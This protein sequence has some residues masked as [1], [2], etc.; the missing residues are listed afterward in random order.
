MQKQANIQLLLDTHIFL[1][2]MNGENFLSSKNREYIEDVIEEEGS[3]GVSAISLW[4]I[5]MLHSRQ[6]ILLDQP[7][8]NW[9][10]H[11]LHAPGIYLAELTPEIAVDSCSL[12][13]E[14]HS[15][16]ADRIIVSTARILDVPLMTKDQKILHYSQKG[17]VHC[18]EA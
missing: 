12:P 11:S 1:W 15:D 14:F 10:T 17:F 2:L 9:F 7:C 3:V 4:E 5:S 8:L 13:G 18:I 6:R 16:P